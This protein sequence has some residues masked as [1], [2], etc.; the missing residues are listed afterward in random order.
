[1]GHDN[2]NY[3]DFTTGGV[4]TFRTGG[5]NRFFNN[6]SGHL[7]IATGGFTF[8]TFNDS[9]LGLGGLNGSAGATL[10]VQNTGATTTR[11]TSIFKAVSSQTA[12]LTQWQNSSGTVLAS[13]SSAGLLGVGGTPISLLSTEGGTASTPAPWLYQMGHTTNAPLHFFGRTGGTTIGA[14]TAIGS[15]T[16]I[17]GLLWQGA[18]GSVMQNVAYQAVVTDGAVS[19]TSSPGY[20]IFSTTPT[21][22]ISVVERMRI[23]SN[24][25]F[26]IGAGALT[27]NASHTIGFDISYGNI[28][29]VVGADAN[30]FTRTN[31]TNKESRMGMPHYPNSEEPAAVFLG[32]STSTANNV[33]IGGGSALMNAATQ[34]GFFTAANNTTVTGTRMMTIDSVGVGIGTLTPSTLLHVLATTEQLRLGYDTSNYF[35]TTV[36]STGS[37]T[38]ALTG[39]SPTFTFSQGVTFSDGITIADAKNI[40][41]N[42]TTGTKIGTAT[43]QK[44]SF[45]NATPIVQPTTAGAAA[46]FVSNTSLIFDDSATFDGYTIGQVVKALRNAGILA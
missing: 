42:T 32:S 41:L 37:T 15:G 10:A 36:G 43:T 46:T 5:A 8:A 38:F 29:L 31:T 9:T 7:T 3:I 40:V 33:F 39:T 24:G 14:R 26:D 18:D 45:W 1:M 12:D 6:T 19:S 21:G 25:T 2:N 4:F 30:A 17:G 22:T 34:I 44:L 35:S 20:M 23:N 16:T 27:S 13:V 28:G 11:V